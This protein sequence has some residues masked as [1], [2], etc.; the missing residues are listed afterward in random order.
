MSDQ[1]AIRL[2]LSST[3]RDF[4]EER[5]LLVKRV[6]PALRAK[7]K[8]RFVELVDVDLRW[9]ITVVEAERGEVLPICLAEIDRSRPYF[10]GMLGERYGWIPPHEG[11][12]PD[13]LER[14]PWLKTHQGGKS[15]TELEILYGVLKNKRM[16]TRAFFYFRSPAYARA[17][18]G[19]YVPDTS[20]DRKRQLD[21]KRRIKDSGY[22]VTGYRDPEALAKR[23]ERDLWKLLDA[24]FPASEVPDAFERERLRHEAYATPRRRLYLGG[25]RY[26]TALEK[27]LD[28]EIPRIVI[29]GASGGGKS[30][31][32]ANFFEAYRKRYRRHLVHEHYLGASADAANPHA[33]VRRFIEFIQSCTDCREDIP[34][35]PQ[36]LM[37]S[38]PMWL[39]TASAWARKRDTRFIFVLD[40]LNS[41]TDQQDLRWWPAFL[42]QCI[43]VVI[44]CLP[45]PVYDA[46]KGKAEPM[47][48]QDKPPTWQTVTVRPL[49]K[50]QSATLLNTYL[51]RFNKKLPQQM[52]KQVQSHAL[53]TNPL[54]LRTLA[55]E[56]RLFGVHE[57]LQN[58]LDH[59]LSSETIDDLFER[60]LERVETDF[61]SKLVRYALTSL[62]ASRSGL[63]EAEL[64]LILGRY[65]TGNANLDDSDGVLAEPMSLPH[66]IWAPIRIALDDMLIEMNGRV[67]FS[68]DYVRLAIKDR[69]LPNT[70]LQR[71]AH[72]ALGKW[73][74]KQ[75]PSPRRAEEEPYQWRKAA[76]WRNLYSCL[77]DAAN[78]ES[79][80]LQ[81]GCPEVFSYWLDWEKATNRPMEMALEEAWRGWALQTSSYETAK[82][83]LLVQKLLMYAGR[84]VVFAEQVGTLAVN[85]LERLPGHH[86]DAVEA[87]SNLAKLHHFRAEHEKALQLA[88]RAVREAVNESAESISCWVNFA[89]ICLALDRHADAEAAYENAVAAAE[90]SLG[91]NSPE[92]NFSRLSQ[93]WLFYALGDYGKSERSFRV[94]Y[95][96]LAT[97]LGPCDPRTSQAANNLAL[98]NFNL[99][100]FD[101]AERLAKLAL[102]NDTA[103]FGNEHWS[104]SLFAL[105]LSWVM[106]ARGA[107]VR[108]SALLKTAI[109]GLERDLGG[110][111]PA[112]ALAKSTQGWYLQVAGEFEASRSSYEAAM[113]TLITSVGTGH[114]DLLVPIEGLGWLSLRQGDSVTAGKH[115]ESANAL[116]LSNYGERHPS[117]CL[118]SCGLALVALAE[119][120]GD[121]ALALA[122]QAAIVAEQAFGTDHLDTAQIYT[123]LAAV[124]AWSGHAREAVEKLSMAFHGR[125]KVLPMTHI[126]L[127][128]AARNLEYVKCGA[129]AKFLECSFDA[130]RFTGSSIV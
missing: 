47:L 70:D 92:A 28:T 13:L 119:G 10:I 61:D 89:D 31:L 129:D 103:L 98:L 8:D 112:W 71:E 80:I 104:P 126:D 113:K 121:D 82:A 44:S 41:L 66:A 35:D 56:L 85:I 102:I 37:D 95:D 34:S 88:R 49:T 3:F 67:I 101:E 26:Q 6:F 53:S 33:L 40:S 91:K 48:G 123:C 22:S 127:G 12:A 69:Y 43:S 52:V 73:F 118:P 46:L 100:R 19:H 63:T 115:F 9:G 78:F 109:V 107:T 68:H 86:A 128:R 111:H 5:D 96:S 84:Y 42:P 94:A 114:A 38:L 122:S 105:N 1:R 60:V 106:H 57:N 55:E 50:P 54:F 20:E 7:L 4:G 16:K 90:T 117:G 23:M 76:L 77:T 25:E 39:A 130:R 18:G 59:Y 11:Y 32:L 27:L 29:E 97:S 120:N 17:K 45:G 83:G 108:A 93:A 110:S 64:M 87:I 30:A 99:C 72:T 14:Q 58:K 75:A 15:V 125:S 79:F 74:S 116:V 51:A 36:K 62:W 81:R 65:R 2:F 124:L 24:E 21:L